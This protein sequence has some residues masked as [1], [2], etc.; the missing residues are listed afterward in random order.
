M[1]TVQFQN[2]LGGVVQ[3]VAVVGDGH[4]SAGKALQELLQPVDAFRIQVVGGFVQQQHVGLAQQQA[5]Q[6][7]AALLATRQVLDHC[8]PGGQVQCICGQFQLQ[9]GV[10]AARGGNDGFQ[11]GLLGRQG[12]KVGVLVS[13]G[14]IH[15]F[16]PGLGSQ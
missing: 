2:P 16:Q 1:A 4:H 13:V 8:I 10:F 9:V 7:H 11:F 14:G 12:I 5:A 3:E 6:G 15:L